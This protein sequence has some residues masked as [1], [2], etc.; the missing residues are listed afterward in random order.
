MI[1]FGKGIGINEEC[2][3]S[4]GYGIVYGIVFIS[5]CVNVCE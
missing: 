2:V 1:F 5:A 4:V 3:S